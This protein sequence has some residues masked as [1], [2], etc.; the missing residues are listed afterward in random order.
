MDS[1]N[2]QVLQFCKKREL[3]ELTLRID[4]LMNELDVS[5]ETVQSWVKN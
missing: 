1:G 4:K 2:K 3:I 5:F